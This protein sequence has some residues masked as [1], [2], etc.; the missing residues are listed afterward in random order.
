MLD[1]EL[2]DQLVDEQQPR[3]AV[4]A[5]TVLRELLDAQRLCPEADSV[6]SEVFTCSGANHEPSQDPSD[7]AS[8]PAGESVGPVAGGQPMRVS[9]VGKSTAVRSRHGRTK[10]KE[11]G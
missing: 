9:Q 8:V 7:V 6:S 1:K 10:V 5:L 3:I 4:R 2:C 11:D